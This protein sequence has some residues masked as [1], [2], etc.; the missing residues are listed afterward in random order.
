MSKQISHF[1][2]VKEPAPAKMS[3]NFTMRESYTQRM[4]LT[5]NTPEC[6]AHVT[7]SLFLLLTYMTLHPLS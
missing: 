5:A 1:L 3:R 7:E 2:A 4:K 6:I